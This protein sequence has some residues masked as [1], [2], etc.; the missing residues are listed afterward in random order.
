[1]A[2]SDVTWG[3]AIRIYWLV[4]WRS[5][6]GGL[7]F[8]VVSGLIIGLF[9]AFAG[10]SKPLTLSAS[11][12]LGVFVGVVWSTNVIRMALRKTYSNFRIVIVNT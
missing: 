1:M 6:V 12:L 3:Q 10:I 8:G 5:L 11:S 2:Q 4:L 7:V 9:G